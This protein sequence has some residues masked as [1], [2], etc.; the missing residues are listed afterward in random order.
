VTE[1]VVVG[2]GIAGLAAAWA[3]RERDLLVLE[4][5]DRAG[6]R[7]RSEP[8]GPYWLNFGAHV[9]AAPD[10]ASGC[11][12]A[13]AGVELR[14]AP[15]RLAAVSLNGKLVASGPVESF[16]LRLPMPP[17]ARLAL[18]RAGVKLRLA[19]RRY[20]S[21][22]RA[23]PGEDPAAR[24]ERVLAF[25]DDRSFAE[26]VGPLPVD[27][28]LLFRS[29]LTRSSGEPEEL[30]AG[31]GV[32]YFHLVWDR[33]GGLSRNVLGGSA[34]ATETLAAAL[35]EKLVLGADVH[36]VEPAADGVRVTYAHG[37]TEH[38]VEARAAI[39][40]TPAYVT[41]EIVAGLPGET[42]TALERI[43]YGPYVVGAFLTREP[44]PMPYDELYAL[45][46]PKRSFSMLFNTANVLRAGPRQPGGSL[47]VYAA[48]GFARRLDGLDDATV[49]E[50]FLADLHDLFPQTRSLVEETVIHRW[51]RGLPY[52]CVGRS[53][54]QR[55]LTRPL[56]AV[57][58]AGDYLGTWYTETAVQTGLAAAAA[59]LRR[60]DT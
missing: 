13:D 21:L 60:L 43:P 47:M 39:V 49:A 5:S 22:A 24:Q 59:A 51:V 25:L 10:S 18:V 3:L 15:G 40:A 35:G 42:A 12:L 56:G 28:D 1:V 32:G 14:T 37:G 29:T 58:L 36:A 2:G 26:L 44:G 34:V 45:A 7:I 4:A 16:P 8:R 41:R 54:L 20:A 48:A 27:A 55:A 52:P 33:T 38:A 30:S 46:T 6:G 23:V 31:Y 11:L 17:A 50:R 19:V 53:L 9:F 57:F